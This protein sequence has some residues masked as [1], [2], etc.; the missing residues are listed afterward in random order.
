MDKQPEKEDGLSTSEA[1]FIFKWDRDMPMGTPTS[2]RFQKLCNQAEIILLAETM[3][4]CGHKM[5]VMK[6]VVNM[7]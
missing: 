6:K 3:A 7:Q 5:A 2:V 4:D 1:S